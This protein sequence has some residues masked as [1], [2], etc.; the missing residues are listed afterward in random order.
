[1]SVVKTVKVGTSKPLSDFNPSLQLT[2][3][4][5]AQLSSTVKQKVSCSV[6]SQ[7]V[8]LNREHILKWA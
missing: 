6:L 7:S 1:M 2:V 5:T 3:W 8:L 4:W